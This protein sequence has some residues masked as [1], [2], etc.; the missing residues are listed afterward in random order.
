MAKVTT[1]SQAFRPAALTSRQGLSEDATAD[2]AHSVHFLSS[3]ESDNRRGKRSPE[4]LLVA[5][6]NAVTPITSITCSI[7]DTVPG[8]V[9]R[10]P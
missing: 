1:Q 4:Y 5:S 10:A 6:A 7:S 9:T 2:E 8:I 3:A